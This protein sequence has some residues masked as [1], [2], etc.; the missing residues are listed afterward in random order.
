MINTASLQAVPCISTHNA[1]LNTNCLDVVR[2]CL[3][4][5]VGH[6]AAGYSGL[7][8]LAG[9]GLLYA[10]A[11]TEWLQQCDVKPAGRNF[12]GRSGTGEP[13]GRP[14]HT[15]LGRKEAVLLH[16]VASGSLSTSGM[17]DDCASMD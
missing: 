7:L 15:A 10:V 1:K 8:P 3:A 6:R 11:A 13:P 14:A 5:P 9:H 2:V 17:L 12:W 4:C 16:L